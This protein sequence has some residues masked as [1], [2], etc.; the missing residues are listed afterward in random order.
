[1]GGTFYSNYQNF[2]LF[3]TFFLFWISI[4]FGEVVEDFIAYILVIS[5]GILHGANDLLILS[6]KE[7]TDKTFIKNLFLYIGIFGRMLFLKHKE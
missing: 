3:I 7:K 5:I 6:I 4:Q 2:M 1:M